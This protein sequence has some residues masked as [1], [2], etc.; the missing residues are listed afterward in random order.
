[1]L[2]GLTYSTFRSMLESRAKRF[3][4]EVIKVNPAFTSLIGHFKFMKKY[5]ISSHSSASMVIARRGL[6]FNNIEKLVYGTDFENKDLPL[7]KTRRQQ[8]SNLSYQTKKFC[9]F[10]DRIELLKVCNY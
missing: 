9:S 3:G 10:N 4:V 8:W 1:M 5:G 2:S 6:R 7:N